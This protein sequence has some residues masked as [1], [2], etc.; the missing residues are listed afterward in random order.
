MSFVDAIKSVFTQYVGFS[1]RARRSEYW[2][3]TLCNCIISGVLSGLARNGGFF[4][5]LSVIWSLAV[6]LPGLAVCVRRLHD[7]GKSGWWLLLAL[8][9]VVGAIILIV[10]FVK[11]SEPGE[12]AYGPNPKEA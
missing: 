10:F 8:I 12:N 6:L 9:P 7:I 5:V 2:Y 1:G 3:W 11:D 4:T